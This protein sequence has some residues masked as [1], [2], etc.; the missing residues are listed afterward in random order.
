MKK[1]KFKT[2]KALKK[3]IRVT[4]TNKLK[5]CCAYK[6]HFAP[7]KT[8]KQKRHL[9]KSRFISKADYHREIKLIQFK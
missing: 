3:R 2:K 1:N 9:R 6:G 5:R 4:A 7:H 8:T